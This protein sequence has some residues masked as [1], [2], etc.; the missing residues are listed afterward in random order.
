MGYVPRRQTGKFLFAGGQL[1]LLTANKAL[2]RMMNCPHSTAQKEAK[3][4]VAFL[5]DLI[6]LP[7]YV[8][9]ENQI[10]VFMCGLKK[11]KVE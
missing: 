8:L 6:E 7:E 1:T 3:R 11:L 4:H 2:G 10:A 5:R 9:L